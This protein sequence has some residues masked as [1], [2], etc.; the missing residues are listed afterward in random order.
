MLEII[1]LCAFSRGV[2]LNDDMCW[3]TGLA[4]KETRTSI[5]AK[6]KKKKIRAKDQVSMIVEIVIV[7][8][9]TPSLRSVSDTSPPP[10]PPP[11]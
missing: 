5:Y 6:E 7:L 11:P 8:H 10:D 2:R 1:C 3:E 4:S 9:P